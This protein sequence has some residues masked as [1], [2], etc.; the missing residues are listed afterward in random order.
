MPWLE[1]KKLII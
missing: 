1:T